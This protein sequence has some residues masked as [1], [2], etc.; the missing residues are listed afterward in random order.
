MTLTNGRCCFNLQLI[1]GLNL[2]VHLSLPLS[3]LASTAQ[4][5]GT[6]TEEESEYLSPKRGRLWLVNTYRSLSPALAR[7][8]GLS[9]RKGRKPKVC[10]PSLQEFWPVG[11]AGCL[12][13]VHLA[14]LRICCI[15]S[16][17]K[18]INRG[19]RETERQREGE[20]VYCLTC[21]WRTLDSNL[22]PTLS[23]RDIQLMIQIWN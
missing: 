9:G 7:H 2:A 22:S 4:H 10:N 19:E 17:G 16:V 20:R 1:L 14:Q 8:G 6:L 21:T 18:Y 3:A 5:L 13:A 12:K 15:L 23:S 11:T